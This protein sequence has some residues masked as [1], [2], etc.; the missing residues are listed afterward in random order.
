[1]QYT[2][3]GYSHAI[4]S[5]SFEYFYSLS[6]KDF[7]KLVNNY[8]HHNQ[9]D[10]AMLCA[11][12]MA[13]K[14]GKEKLTAE[15]AELCCA[16]FRYMGMIYL[17]VY[18]NYQLAAENLLKAKQI[19]DKYGLYQIG[20]HIALNEAILTAMKN[21]LENNFT[22]SKAV[23]NGFKGAFKSS[24]KHAMTENAVYHSVIMETCISN[25]LC[26][27]IKFDKPQEVVKEVQAYHEAQKQY[28]SHDNIA[29]VL[30]STIEGINAGNYDYALEVL[31]TPIAH[32]AYLNDIDFSQMQSMIKVAQYAVLIKGGKR[33]DA[34]KLL[35]QHEQFTRD[36]KLNFELLE[37]LQLLKKHY[38]KDG[39]K[40]MADKYALAYYKTK[41]EFINKSR[42]GKMDEAKLNLELEQ[43]RIKIQEMRYRQKVQTVVLW[44]AVIIA[45]LVIGFLMMA[46]HNNKRN[47]KKDIILYERQ[48]ERLKEKLTDNQPQLTTEAVPAKPANIEIQPEIAELLDQIVKVMETSTEVYTEGFSIARLAELTDSNTKYVSQAINDIK[49]CSFSKLLAEK[50]INEACKRL[51]DTEHYGQYTIEAIAHSVGYK[52]RTTFISV[53]KEIV[54][55]TP[56]AF[57]KM[58]KAHKQTSD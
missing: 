49:H 13:S 2:I 26:F 48:I 20:T 53:F 17:N 5:D 56:S 45:L 44:S 52:S 24:M 42:A 10:S 58:S 19:A 7:I 23:I 29:N 40:A 8:N 33:D 6:P 39:N 38:E 1:M 3:I 18:S 14:Y 15:D 25:L 9:I 11:N 30:C 27:A 35:L 55:L 16:S 12:I 51:L 37:V 32:P 50:R 46:Y 31:R 34:L 57:Q 36:N 28:N 22:Y 47:H 54:G 43:T 4:K 21:D 41:D